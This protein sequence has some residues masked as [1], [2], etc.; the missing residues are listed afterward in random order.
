MK[1]SLPYAFLLLVFMSSCSP[2]IFKKTQPRDTEALRSIPA[3]FIGTYVSEEELKDTITID[4]HAFTSNGIPPIAGNMTDGKTVI[5]TLADNYIL[6]TS[7]GKYW[8]TFIVRTTPN[9]LTVASISFEEEKETKLSKLESITKVK[10]IKDKDH[11][12]ITYLIN[13]TKEEF[14]KIMASGIFNQVMKFRRIK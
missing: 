6:N 7:T 13:P 1:K 5:K 9:G 12:K 3:Q 14:E 10:Q 2:V 11:A 8:E 4:A